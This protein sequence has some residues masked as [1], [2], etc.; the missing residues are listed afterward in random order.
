[1]PV[2]SFSA[3]H[4]AGASQHVS[5]PILISIITKVSRSILHDET[6]RSGGYIVLCR[7]EAK[8]MGKLAASTQAPGVQG[9]CSNGLAEEIYA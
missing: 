5:I 6:R 4:Y 8:C 9:L 2:L 1:M 3:L 7:L